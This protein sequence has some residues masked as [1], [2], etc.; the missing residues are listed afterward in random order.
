MPRSV[1]EIIEQ[2]EGLAEQFERFEPG[3]KDR[4]RARSLAALHRAA[5]SRARAEAKLVEVVARARDDG[6]SWT[7]IGAMLGTSGEAARQ[8]YGGKRNRT[9]RAV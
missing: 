1:Y 9:A 3:T 8:R 4:A 7:A 6:H 5:L 2:A